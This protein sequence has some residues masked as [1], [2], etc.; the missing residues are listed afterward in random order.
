MLDLIKDDAG[1][2]VM[3]YGT[4][5]VED[6]VPEATLVTGVEIRHYLMSLG[7]KSEDIEEALGDADA[8]VTLFLPR[9]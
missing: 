4:R 1:Y 2:W 5:S 7:C 8:G 6:G 9:G 3:N